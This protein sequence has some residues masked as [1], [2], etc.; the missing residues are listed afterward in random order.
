MKSIVTTLVIT[1][2]ICCT[3]Q[4][5]ISFSD[6]YKKY[7]DTPGIISGDNKVSTDGI[8]IGDG[9]GDN[10]WTLYKKFDHIHYIISDS[11]NTG[12]LMEMKNNLPGKGYENLGGIDNWIQVKFKGSRDHRNEI[13][14]IC[15]KPG[16]LSVVCITGSFGYDEVKSNLNSINSFIIAHNIVFAD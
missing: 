7:R 3:V 11:T 4:S 8:L 9:S 6:F 14:M 16:S 1:F 13:L 12:I 5:Q 2:F 10:I 15:S